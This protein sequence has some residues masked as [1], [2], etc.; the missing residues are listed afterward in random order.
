MT[1]MNEINSLVK[2]VNFHVTLNLTLNDYVLPLFFSDFIELN[3]SLK[4]V[5]ILNSNHSSHKASE[6][7]AI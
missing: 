1:A 3:S 7:L 2:L 5:W 6:Q 4:H